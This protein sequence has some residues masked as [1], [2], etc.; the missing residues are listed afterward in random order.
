MNPVN[1]FWTG[2]KYF[3]D[4]KSLITVVIYYC[5]LL[6]FKNS[7]TQGGFNAYLWNPPKSATACPNLP[8]S[9][10]FLCSF[11]SIEASWVVCLKFGR[12]LTKWLILWDLLRS[13]IHSNPSLTNIDKF[14]HLMSL[15]ESSAAEA[16]AGL[17]IT[18]EKYDKVIATLKKRY[19]NP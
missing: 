13:S 8:A 1:Y 12:E 17:T 10:Y 3:C 4:K 15:V 19:D 7:I 2:Q 18:S 11:P 14:N 6:N 5:W 16:I 9:P